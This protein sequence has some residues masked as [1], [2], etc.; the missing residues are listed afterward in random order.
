[1]ILIDTPR[2]Q[3]REFTLEDVDAVY[4][5]SSHPQVIEFTGDKLVESR[6][7]AKALIENVWLKEYQQYGYARYALIHKLDARIIGFCGI[8]F[9]PEDNLP[10]IGYRMLPVYW[11]QGLATEAVKATLQYAKEKLKLFKIFGEAVDENIASQQV[12]LKSGLQHVA[13]YQKYGYLVHRF[14]TQW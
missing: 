6:E 1:M 9:E 13:Q 5:F 4:E 3:M 12:M 2:L 11:G 8:K 14:E 7:N 10:D